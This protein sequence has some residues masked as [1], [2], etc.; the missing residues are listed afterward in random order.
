VESDVVAD[1][2]A[3][4]LSLR[5]DRQPASGRIRIAARLVMVAPGVQALH[6]I[7]VR[8][9]VHHNYVVG[10]RVSFQQRVERRFRI[11][12]AV[13]VEQYDAE[14]RIMHS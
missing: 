12:V 10:S 13:P 9:V 8:T 6:R 14:R 5:Y 1:R 7:V 3:A 4:I 2:E 11:R